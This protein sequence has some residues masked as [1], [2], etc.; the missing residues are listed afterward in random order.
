M[1]GQDILCCDPFDE[2]KRAVVCPV[3]VKPLST[4]VWDGVNINCSNDYTAMRSYVI[5]QLRS[6]QI[7]ADHLRT[8]NPTP[9]K[10]S[11]SLELYQQMHDLMTEETTIERLT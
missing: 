5:E 1:P 2:T 8:L 11:L 9:Y 4:L 10:V 3:S 6:G 7:R